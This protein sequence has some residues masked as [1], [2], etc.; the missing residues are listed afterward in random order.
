M[1]AVKFSNASE[2]GTYHRVPTFHT[3]KDGKQT[4]PNNKNKKN[5]PSPQP[6][7]AVRPVWAVGCWPAAAALPSPDLR[8][9]QPGMCA[10]RQDSE[11][12]GRGSLKREKEKKSHN[13]PKNI[14]HK[15]E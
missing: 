6:R 3:S 13:H 14:L 8:P 10:L 4:E 12:P 2:K 5:S 1:S 11:G 9:L 15:R 7:D